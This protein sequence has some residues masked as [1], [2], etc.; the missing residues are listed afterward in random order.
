MEKSKQVVGSSSSSFTT[1][2]FGPKEPSNSSLFGSVFGPPSTGLRR[3][4]I[5]A[6][7]KS[8]SRTQEVGN[9]YGNAKYGTSD[10]GSKRSRGEKVEAACN[11]SSSIYYG[12]QDI[13]SPI[14]TQPPCS[15]SNIVKKDGGGD[16]SNSASRGNWW[17]GS[18]YY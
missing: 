16:G 6:V 12:G 2:L 17:Q 4:P 5:H 14:N 8:I 13:Y 9:Q 7:D 1:E 10:N 11:F 18:L 3:D 15:Q